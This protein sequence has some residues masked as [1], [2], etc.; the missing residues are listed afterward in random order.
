MKSVMYL[1][2]Q[3]LLAIWINVFLVGKKMLTIIFLLKFQFM[4][5]SGMQLISLHK[6]K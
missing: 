5:K 2:C 4:I 3:V 6:V 1:F